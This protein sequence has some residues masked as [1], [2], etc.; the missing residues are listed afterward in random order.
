M[1]RLAL[2]LISL[3]LTA[4]ACSSNVF[5]LEVG[6]CFDDPDA[7]DQVSN[8]ELVGCTEAH[9][10][11]VYHVF[12]MTDADFPGVEAANTAAEVGC[13]GAFEPYV[14]RDFDSSSLG[15]GYLTPSEESWEQDDREIVCFAYDFNNAKLNASVKSSGL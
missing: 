5:A 1:K 2:L 4:T 12:D 9:D 10:N 13:L 6:N 7:F 11:E 14:G 3:A 15:L 8:V